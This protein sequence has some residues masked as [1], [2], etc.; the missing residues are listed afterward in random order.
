MT[1]IELLKEVQRIQLELA[2]RQTPIHLSISSMPEQKHIGICVQNTD[3]EVLFYDIAYDS[4]LLQNKVEEIYKKLL[5]VIDRY[6]AVRAA[7]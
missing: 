5:C 7:G 4:S 3:H 2:I 6:T 1:T